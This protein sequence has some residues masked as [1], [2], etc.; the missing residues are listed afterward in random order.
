MKNLIKLFLI[1]MMLFSVSCSNEPIT[2]AINGSQD[3]D[4]FS[5]ATKSSVPILEKPNGPDSEFFEINGASSTLHRNKNGITVNFNT[6]GL[7]P[8]NAYTM[9]FIVFGDAPGPPNVTYAA[10]LIAGGSGKANFSAHKSVGSSFNNPLTAEVHLVI[11]SHGQAVP[12]LIPAQIQ[13]GNGGCITSEP[14]GPG[15]IY[16]DS[17]ELGRCADIQVAMHP[18][19]N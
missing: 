16:P 3:V 2:E 8:N 14:G 15:K 12:G 1:A 7:I 9:W 10:G 5:R 6:N 13:T 18:K 19:V 4:N 17:D 11:K